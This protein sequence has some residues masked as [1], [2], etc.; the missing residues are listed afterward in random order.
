MAGNWQFITSHCVAI[1]FASKILNVWYF[2]DLS[3]VH[4]GIESLK[5][6]EYIDLTAASK[7]TQTNI[8]LLYFV[9][10]RRDL[11]KSGCYQYNIST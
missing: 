7:N 1:F 8:S 2:C 10:M 3:Q 5:I 9:N 11:N 4:A 6:I